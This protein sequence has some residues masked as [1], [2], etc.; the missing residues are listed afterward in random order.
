[1]AGIGEFFVEAWK[2]IMR[3]RNYYTLE[4]LREAAEEF[5]LSGLEQSSSPPRT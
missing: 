3:R 2:T 4:E 1:L 5:E